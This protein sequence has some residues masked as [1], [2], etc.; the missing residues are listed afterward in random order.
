MRK[1][2]YKIVF[3][4][5]GVSKVINGPII[6]TDDIFLTIATPTGKVVIN[7]K[8]IVFMREMREG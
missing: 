6:E 3:N 1:E 8:N 4:D 5:A 2:K 7:K